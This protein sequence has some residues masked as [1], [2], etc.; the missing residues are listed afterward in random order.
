MKL[1]KNARVGLLQAGSVAAYVFLIVNL[2]PVM[3]RYNLEPPKLVGGMVFLLLFVTSA[4]ICG[5][6]TLFHPANLIFKGKVQDAVEVIAW[7]GGWLI[8]ILAILL[9]AA[10]ILSS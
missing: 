8:S 6:L 1:S 7:T 9:A 3:D 4:F 5:T 2:I 10:V